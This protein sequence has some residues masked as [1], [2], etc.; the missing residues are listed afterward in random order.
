MSATHNNTKQNHSFAPLKSIIIKRAGI[1]ITARWCKPKR[2]SIKLVGFMSRTSTPVDPDRCPDCDNVSFVQQ[3][4]CTFEPR[5]N[6]LVTYCADCG[7]EYWRRECGCEIAYPTI[8]AAPAAEQPE[9]E[10]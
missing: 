9:Q 4:L 3:N 1:Y 10:Y 2:L 6:A 8:E 5:C 7:W